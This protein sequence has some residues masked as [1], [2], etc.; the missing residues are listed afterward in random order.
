MSVGILAAHVL[1]ATP[2]HAEI[3]VSPRMIQ[4]E[5]APSERDEQESLF[6]DQF[7]D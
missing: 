7:R 4:G 2:L 1:A 6:N 5:P 3:N